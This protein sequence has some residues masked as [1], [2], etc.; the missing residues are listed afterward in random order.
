MKLKTCSSR[1]VFPILSTIV[2]TCS[3]S[4]ATSDVWDGSTGSIWATGTNWATDPLVVPGATETA[5]FSGPGNGNT[6]IDLGAGITIGSLIFDS[7]NAAGYTIG[8]GAPSSQVLTLNNAG[9]ITVNSNVATNQL[10][11]SAVNLGTD[12]SAASYTLTNNS[13]ANPITFA[14]GI[15]GGSGGSAGVKAL[16]VTGGGNTLIKGVISTGGGSFLD[17]IKTGTGTL[18]LSGV[19]TY[20]GGTRANQG[21]VILSGTRLT[22]AFLSLNNVGAQNAVVK[23]GAGATW[24]FNDIQVGEA[25]NSRGAVYQTGGAIA[26]TRTANIASFRIGGAGAS[27]YGYY[28]LSGGTVTSNEFGLGG[29][30]NGMGVMDVS[31]GQVN[32]PAGRYVTVARGGG[33]SLGLL[34]VTGGSVTTGRIALNWGNA[35]GGVGVMNVGGGSGSA[36]VTTDSS[37]AIGVEVT[38]SGTAGTS[39]VVNL[40]SNGT[41]ATGLL[42]GA[43]AAS[44]G[45]VNFNGG[46]LKATAVNAGANFLNSANIDAVTIYHGGGTID[47]SGTNISIG[48][49]LE[50]ATGTGVTSIAVTNGGSGY[51]GAPVVRFGDGTGNTATAYAKMVDDGTGAGTFKV[52]SIVITSAGTYSINPSTVTLAGGGAATSATLGSITMAANTSGG[53]NFVGTGVTTLTA[54]SNYSGPTTVGAGSTLAVNGNI[55]TSITSVSGTLIGSGSVAN[56]TILGGGTLAPG[57]SIE[58]LAAGTVGFSTG[59]TFAYEFDSA[60][61]NGDLLASSGTL[62][63][64]PGTLLSLTQLASGTVPL[65][66]KL[67]L[68]SYGGGWT[69]TELFTYLG[70]PL[71]DDSTFVLGSNTWLFNYNDVSGGS[72]FAPD[73]S[74]A[75][76]FIT[77]TAV[78]EPTT[79]GL[80]SIGLLALLRRRR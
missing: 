70:N 75:T 46:M 40:L 25:A 53:M 62:D 68:I 26:S 13:L 38:V 32:A 11:N 21:T 55:T 45:L 76:S 73:Q 78:P 69:P 7:A 20:N 5:T 44:S 79:L 2:L 34:N 52:D 65:G 14:G 49:S 63:I 23:L 59:S 64:A 36:A 16:N 4:S 9:A 39:G 42:T 24:N 48:K 8:T 22:G 29:G 60:S 67:S 54:S 30:T 56:L 12:G 66:A 19:N 80:G 57:N 6:V 1:V 58:S 18:E 43:G 28:G 15:S 33:A 35:A 77:M 3:S 74:G 31:G 71:A 47:N 51:I 17:V 10:F 61:L 27:S 37:A 41:L 72:N 50:A